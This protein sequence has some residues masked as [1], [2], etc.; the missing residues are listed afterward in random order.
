MHISSIQVIKPNIWHNILQFQTKG[1][2]TQYLL[3]PQ[4]MK[5]P[6]VNDLLIYYEKSRTWNS[7]DKVWQ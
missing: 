3:F 6:I 2:L 5:E 4:F 7:K 1:K